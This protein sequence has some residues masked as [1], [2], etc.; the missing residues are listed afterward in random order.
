MSTIGETSLRPEPTTRMSRPPK[1]STAALHDGLALGLVVWAP[2]DGRDFGAEFAALSCG[3]LEFAA[4]AG[5]EDEAGPGCGENARGERAEGTGGAGHHRDFAAHV[6][7]ASRVAQQIA[8]CAP[9][10]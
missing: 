1:R 3:R 10:G 6:E 2:R 4:I 7:E 9:F 8:H 5:R